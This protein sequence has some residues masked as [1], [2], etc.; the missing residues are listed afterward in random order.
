MVEKLL[1]DNNAYL[2]E[3]IW[4]HSEMKYNTSNDSKKSNVQDAT[5]KFML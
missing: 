2:F 4:L 1:F 3:N 5:Q